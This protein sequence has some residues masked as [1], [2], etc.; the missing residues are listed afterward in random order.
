[1]TLPPKSLRSIF[2]DCQ[3]YLERG[4]EGDLGLW[5][6]LRQPPSALVQMVVAAHIRDQEEI[7]SNPDSVARCWLKTFPRICFMGEILWEEAYP[8]FILALWDP[9]IACTVS[10]F[11]HICLDEN[12]A[13]LFIHFYYPSLTLFIRCDL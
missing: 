1:M 10:G 13:L 12:S 3:E 4:Q 2:F 8:L 5:H 7:A 6:L 9:L 11:P